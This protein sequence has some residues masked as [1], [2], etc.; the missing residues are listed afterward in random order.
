[1]IVL[2]RRNRGEL[3][4]PWPLT[5]EKIKSTS[6]TLIYDSLLIEKLGFDYFQMDNLKH[7]SG[8]YCGSIIRYFERLHKFM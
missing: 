5:H 2:A 7:N 3:L 1:M 8:F 6:N 4:K